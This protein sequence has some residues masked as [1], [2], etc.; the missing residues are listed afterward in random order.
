MLLSKAFSAIELSEVLSDIK[1]LDH[2]NAHTM[3]SS[4]YISETFNEL[5]KEYIFR[6]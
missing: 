6:R 3:P 5:E 1:K 2:E 4:F